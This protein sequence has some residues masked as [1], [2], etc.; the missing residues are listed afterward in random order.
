MGSKKS[1]ATRE[2]VQ[3]ERETVKYQCPSCGITVIQA[4]LEPDG[5]ASTQPVCYMHTPRQLMQPVGQDG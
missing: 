5:K 1:K 4:V 3:A 2:R